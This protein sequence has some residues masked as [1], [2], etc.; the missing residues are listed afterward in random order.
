MTT[1]I[2][3]IILIGLAVIGVG[4]A[5]FFA[6]PSEHD[7]MQRDVGGAPNVLQVSSDNYDFGTI[8]MKNGKVSTVFTVKNLTGNPIQLTKLYTSCMC[9]ISMLKMGGIVE[10]PFGMPGHGAL[11]TFRHMLEINAEAQLEVTFDPNAHGP[12]GVGTIER[13]VTLE[14]DS[15]KL[16]TVRIKA[17]V[18]P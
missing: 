8:S 17:T 15:G 18:V 9:T 10:G 2:K 6:Q 4:V 14:G 11:K 12:A 16:A 3:I 7:G 1:Q 5:L 13:E